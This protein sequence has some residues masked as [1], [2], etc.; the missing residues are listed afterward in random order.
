MTFDPRDVLIGLGC[1]GHLCW[2]VLGLTFIL[3]SMWFG[4]QPP[5]PPIRRE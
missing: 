2:G 5:M 1:F 4:R 3:L